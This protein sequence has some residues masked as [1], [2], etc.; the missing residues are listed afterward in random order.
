MR[1]LMNLDEF[2]NV[3]TSNVSN[4]DASKQFHSYTNG[5]FNGK[6][7]TNSTATNFAFPYE[8][9]QQQPQQHHMNG[10]LKPCYDFSSVPTKSEPLDEGNFNSGFATKKSSQVPLFGTGNSG[11]GSGG[12]MNQFSHH[13]DY[14][15]AANSHHQAFATKLNEINNNNTNSSGGGIVVK[16]ENGGN[17]YNNA[18]RT[19]TTNSG[20]SSTMVVNK[21]EPNE[22]RNSCKD[23]EDDERKVSLHP[24]DNDSND[25]FTQL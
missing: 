23:N 15:S 20:A 7:L 17:D 10:L 5:V 2:Q 22:F 12:F 8:K 25:G 4:S 13:H 11:G 21:T 9:H 19:A 14:G 3:A 18:L 16:L 6:M 24:H 1:K